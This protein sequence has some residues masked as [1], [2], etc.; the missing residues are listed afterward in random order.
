MTIFP[1]PGG[2]AVSGAGQSPAALAAA[3]HLPGGIAS[4]LRFFLNLPA[5]LQIPGI[6]LGSLAGA[7]LVYLL[8]RRRRDIGR[9]I[10]TRQRRV[11]LALA[12]A[13]GA[14]ALVAAAFGLVS[15]HYVERN[16]GFCTGCHVMSPAFLA[17]T[18]S[19]HDT[20]ACHD[21]HQQSMYANARQFYL[22]I[23]ERPK[24]I[25]VHKHVQNRVCEGCHATGQP[26]FWRRIEQTAGHRTHLQSDS[27]VLRNVECV[28]CH[29]YQVHHFV[30]ADSTCGQH[31]C[32]TSIA[33]KLGKMKGQTDLHCVVCHRFTADV[34]QFVSY[35]SARGTLVPTNGQCLHCHAMQKVLADFDPARDPHRGTCGDCHNPHTQATPAEA[36]K[37]CA[38]AKC[39]ADWRGDPFHVGRNHRAVSENC[40]LCHEPH[41]AKV[42]PSDCAGC[43]ARV[44]AKR[45]DL[46][47]P[48]PFDTTKA[49]KG[50]KSVSL[51]PPGERPPDRPKGKGDARVDFSPAALPA[52][53]DT[54]PHDRHK[55]LACIT[56]HASQAQHGRL[57]FEPPRGCQIC[58]HQD[59]ARAD[60]LKCHAPA[61]V[62]RPES[63]L[64]RVAVARQPV[65][66]HPA[67]FDHARHQRLACV[68]CHN[69]AVTLA[70]DS[71]TLSCAACHDDHH[72]AGRACA[73][74]HTATADSAVRAAHAPPA[75]A[76]L[77]CAACHQPAIVAGLVPDRALC[78][79][80]H[81]KQR[82]HYA[83]RECTVCHFG[84]APGAYAARL[85]SG[86]P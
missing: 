42:D 45:A 11:K 21:C 84:A 28:K 29:G 24:E 1:G 77:A 41:H 3:P 30:P 39:H 17:F 66:R 27:S 50:A 47:P 6:L 86:A 74:C 65:R 56:C 69:T 58:H 73:S 57:T 35:D 9:W 12:A 16:N 34:P 26:E 54:F 23:V 48:L 33:I 38:T 52:A 76:H 78:E 15:Y 81:A 40:I 32:H 46:T 62:A 14:A 10:V 82:D 31:G 2:A 71:A 80:C 20:L 51:A 61:E 8:W 64:V 68:T 72:T 55:S 63:V 67:V 49:L 60:C 75:D 25:G 13:A 5:W 85:R 36:A 19:K 43:H 83:D 4:V 53:P 79:T 70:P 44:R 59:A 7:A 37:T 18:G 22:W